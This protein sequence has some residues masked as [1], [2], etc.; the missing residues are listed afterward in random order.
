MNQHGQESDSV[1]FFTCTAPS[2]LSAPKFVKSTMTS[3]TLEWN[4]P[5]DNGGCPILSYYLMRDDGSSGISSIE[6][7]TNS[8]SFIRN[9]PTLR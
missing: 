7:N 4:E 6:V 2:G 1:L 3:M 8:D 9:K 5:A